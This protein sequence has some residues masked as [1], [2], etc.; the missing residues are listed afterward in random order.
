MG[1]E[2]MVASRGKFSLVS[3]VY[4]GM[5]IDLDDP[6][7]ALA[8][9]HKASETIPF[10]G[11]LGCDDSTVELAAEVA[12][13]LG[14]PHNPPD[15]ARISARKD[16]ARSSL[17]EA[18]CSVPAHR[19]INLKQ[20]LQEQAAGINL[21]CVLKPLHL[22]ASRGVI[23]V[24][25][26][27]QF[28]DACIRIK[29]ITAESAEPFLQSHLLAEDY[30]DGIEIAYEGF[31]K[32]GEL[33]TL[34]IFDKPDPLTGPFFEE[35]IYVTPTRLDH[36]TQ[37]EISNSVI[38][39]CQAYGLVTGAVHAE[40]R[41]NK[42]AAWILEVASRTIGGECARVLDNGSGYSLEQLSIALAMGQP[43]TVELPEQVRGVMMIPTR[44]GGI[45]RRVEGIGKAQEIP[46]IERIDIAIREGNELIP[47]PEG[48]QY[49]GYIFARGESYAQ[50]VD[51]LHSAHDQLKFVVA[52][53]FKLAQH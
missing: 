9:L 30:I 5:H 7:A 36:R 32:D 16:L 33:T 25:N 12:R 39:A 14:L 45:L 10:G 23:R 46:G 27:E 41:V 44:K 11:I 21:P 26:A 1:L 42:Q 15:A 13:T 3:E 49:L 18:G 28:I 53:V 19:L 17:A 52:P 48:N 31:L 51:A 6:E 29:A 40:L 43:V 34:A 20:P 22:S 24:D 47:L 4:Q 2:V 38:R 8:R 35:T 37:E 50:V